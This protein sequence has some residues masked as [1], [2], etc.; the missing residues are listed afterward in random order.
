MD[1]CPCHHHVPLGGSVS[2]TIHLFLV[3]ELR[4]CGAVPHLSYNILQVLALCF[5]RCMWKL[6]GL[7]H[8]LMT[9]IL[10]GDSCVPLLSVVCY[11]IRIYF[12]EK[13]ETGLSQSAGVA[14]VHVVIGTRD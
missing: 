9:G 7:H 13:N 6:A 11:D 8:V 14:L 1:F 2:L 5:L 12:W 3:Q 10:G 4:M